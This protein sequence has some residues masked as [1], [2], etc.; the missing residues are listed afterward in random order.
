M[1]KAFEGTINVDIRDSVPDWA[2]RAAQGPEGAPNVVYIVLAGGVAG[3][4]AACVSNASRRP[5]RGAPGAT[6]RTT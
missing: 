5:A 2:L 1:S 3:R 4:Y 6:P